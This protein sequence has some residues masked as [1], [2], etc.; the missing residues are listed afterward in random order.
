MARVSASPGSL[1]HSFAVIPAAEIQRSSFDRS[2]GVKTAFNEAY[3]YP[4]YVDEALPGDTFRLN[5]S[6]VVRMSTPLYPVMDNIYADVFFFAVPNRLIWDNWVKF[7]GEQDDPGDSIAYSVPIFS[8]ATAAEESLSD[9]MGIPIG[10]AMDF[11][12]LHHRAY[13]LIYNT[14]FRDEDLVDSVVVDKDDGP[15]TLSDYVL[16]KRMKRH[17]YFASCRPWTQKGTAVELPLGSSAPVEGTGDL[18]PEFE[19]NSLTGNTLYKFSGTNA[20]GISGSPTG[21]PYDLTWDDPKL[22]A[23]LSSA[24]GPLINELR[25]AFQV[26]RLMERDAR[27]G[28]RYT[29]IIRSHFGVVSDDARLQRPEY[30]GGGSVRINVNPVASTVAASRAVGDL[31]GFA[32]GQGNGIGFVKSFTEHCVLLGLVNVRAELTYQQGLNRMFS[33]QTRYDYYWPSLAHLGEQA[34]LTKEIFADGSANDD[35]VFGYIPRYDEYRYKPSVVTGV[36][37]SDHSTP[38]DGWHLALDFAS[39]PVLNQTFMEEAPPFTRIEAVAEDARFIG[40]FW[41]SMKCARPMPMHAVPG[42]VDHF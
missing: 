36:M 27:G 38:L 40:D 16:L 9:Y 18:K 39:Y 26:Q 10:N 11:N 41:F 13:N 25:E 5:T 31:G 35:L 24:T 28:S 19:F 4:I 29:E 23:D 7:C 12:S 32:V 37:R 15:D 42:L 8:S 6:F 30:L 33:R 17:D 2:H 34:V 14:W 20:V 21:G 1:Q 22:Q 3:L